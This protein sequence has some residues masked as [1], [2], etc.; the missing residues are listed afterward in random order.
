MSRTILATDHLLQIY[1][2]FADR[3][4]LLLPDE[5]PASDAEFMKAEVAR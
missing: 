3:A 2:L 1:L 4:S 5:V